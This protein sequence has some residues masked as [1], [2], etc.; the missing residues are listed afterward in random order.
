MYKDYSEL[1]IEA[2]TVLIEETFR[3]YGLKS[4][5]IGN[6][7]LAL[8]TKDHL[9][10]NALQYVIFDQDL[11]HIKQVLNQLNFHEKE[12]SLWHNETCPFTI[13]LFKEYV[14]SGEVVSN[15]FQNKMPSGLVTML[16]PLDCMRAKLV[17]YSQ[18]QD[19]LLLE[20]AETL[21]KFQKIDLGELR[22]FAEKKDLL[23]AFDVLEDYLRK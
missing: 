6:G 8:Y 1:D 12:D 4:A 20:Q 2:L 15:F 11:K 14:I 5:L 22:I 7:A 13:E 18:T 17:E 19:P 9:P 16:F 21:Y 23:K 10:T 3:E